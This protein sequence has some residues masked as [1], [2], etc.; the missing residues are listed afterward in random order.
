M[1]TDRSTNRALAFLFV[2][3]LIDAIG[4]GVVIPV[5][6]ALIVRLTGRSL[7]GAAE[8]AGLIMFLYAI[9][10]FLCG[11]IIGGL[12]DRFGRRPVLL[13]S[14]A[15]FGL[16]YLAMAFAPTLAWLIAAR[17]VAG[18]T[19]A[20][21][22]TA[23]AYI[24]DISPP[25]KRA[26][27][28]GIIGMAFGFGFII[29]PALG[30]IVAQY[31][32]R[33][34][35]LLAAGLALANVAYGYFVLPESLKPENRRP[36]EWRRANPAGALMR[37]RAAHPRVLMLALTVLLWT[38]G[39]Q[40]LYATWSYFGIE[41]FGWTPGQVGWSLAAVGVTGA[42][43]QGV[44]SRR[45]IP[46]YG[47]RNIVIAGTFSGIAGYLI[48]AFAGAGWMMYVGITVAALQGLVFPSLQGMMS[49]GVAPS[50]QGELQGAVS[51]I[52]SLS[53]IMGPPLM[54]G[55]FA[56]FSSPGAPF[57]LPGA[58]FVLAAG[59]SILTLATFL[60]AVAMGAG[61]TGAQAPAE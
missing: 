40:S 3:V 22:P 5:F 48:Y 43:V 59:F 60:R 41:R 28:F 4:F 11:P 10:Q 13:A 37:L 44:L 14:L 36:F 7:A 42:L 49:A 23:Y 24:A 6:P 32:A 55:S 16:D 38:M 47:A 2:T 21:F 20:S 34:P 18:V 27:N 25:E 56:Y 9:T 51:S 31:D 8:V 45:L 19:G 26:P 30:G 58:P 50:E 15:A 53:S 12:S 61:A 1:T 17:L 35:F 54:T 57:Y 52:Q 33:L 46:R 29:G 39:Y